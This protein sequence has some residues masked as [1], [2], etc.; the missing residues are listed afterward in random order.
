MPN[1]EPRGENSINNITESFRTTTNTIQ[2]MANSLDA[3]IARL[4]NISPIVISE[5]I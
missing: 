2:E 5:G 3:Y 4:R 1:T